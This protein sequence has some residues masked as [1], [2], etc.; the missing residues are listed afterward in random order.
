[1]RTDPKGPPGRATSRAGKRKP[2]D[3]ARDLIYGRNAALAVLRGRRHVYEVYVAEGLERDRRIEECLSAAAD[4]RAPIKR[5]SPTLIGNLVGKVNHQGIVVAT[6][7]FGYVSLGEVAKRPGS[8]L[9]LNHVNDPQNFGAVLRAGLAFGIA[10][11]VIPSDRA[12][13]VTPA[14]VNSSA[15]AVEE[16]AVAQVTN[17]PRGLRELRD[18]G[19]WILGL[20]TGEDSQ[21]LPTTDVPLPAAL[22]LGSEGRGISAQVRKACDLIVA[23]PIEESVES[24]NVATA[25]AIALYELNR[26]Q[27][28]LARERASAD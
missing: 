4:R 12:V 21:P 5:A 28:A 16:L 9:V 1:M 17:L 8:V 22:V 24:L 26:R 14:V 13:A 27:A 7:R 25:G 23:I 20:D 2:G 19:R 6:D 10:G 3:R 15:G 18:G 11:V